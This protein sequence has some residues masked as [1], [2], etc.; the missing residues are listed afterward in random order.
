M[1][2]IYY[3]LIEL[4]LLIKLYTIYL[5]VVKNERISGFIKIWNLKWKWILVQIINIRVI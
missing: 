4:Y 5:T 2:N 1:Y 3:T